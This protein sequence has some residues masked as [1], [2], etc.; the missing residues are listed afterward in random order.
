MLLGR[1]CAGLRS[2]RIV[3][4]ALSGKL[5]SRMVGLLAEDVLD[6]LPVAATISGVRLPNAMDGVP[7]LTQSRISQSKVVQNNRFVVTAFDRMCGDCR[8]PVALD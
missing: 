5:G 4:V 6:F 3:V 8:Y 1:D 7:H 2:S